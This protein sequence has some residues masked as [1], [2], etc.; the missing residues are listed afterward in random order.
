MVVAPRLLLAQQLSAEFTEHITNAAVLHVHSGSGSHHTTTNPE[1][2]VVAGVTPHYLLIF[3]GITLFI[4]FKSL[5]YLYMLSTLMKCTTQS[6]ISL[7]LPGLSLL[8]LAA[9]ISLLLLLS[10]L[11]LIGG[12]HE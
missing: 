3:T 6:R 8:V 9:V 4:V 10:T 5:I 2:L 11:P 12:R 1:E 7:V